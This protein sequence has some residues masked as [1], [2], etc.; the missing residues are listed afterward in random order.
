MSSPKTSDKTPEGNSQSKEK[1]RV[2]PGW[3]V[4]LT[5]CFLLGV[6]VL[7]GARFMQQFQMVFY[8]LAMILTAFAILVW[9]A[10]A[11][12]LGQYGFAQPTKRIL[13]ICV[14]VTLVAFLFFII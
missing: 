11:A 8:T 2:I 3:S 5:A 4:L 12:F 14:F 10:F 9:S 6:L 7:V 1:Q 13:A